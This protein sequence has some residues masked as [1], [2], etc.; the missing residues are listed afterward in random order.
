MKK[1]LFTVLML[2]TTISMLLAEGI[3]REKIMPKKLVYSELPE[4]YPKELDELFQFYYD[5]AQAILHEYEKIKKDNK[6]NFVKELW[7]FLYDRIENMVEEKKFRILYLD[8]LARNTIPLY[9]A[10]FIAL[11]FNIEFIDSIPESE[12]YAISYMPEE[13]IKLWKNYLRIPWIGKIRGAV[14][15]DLIEKYPDKKIDFI[16]WNN[17]IWAKGIVQESEYFERKTSR[18]GANNTKN[19]IKFK[20]TDTIASKFTENEIIIQVGSWGDVMKKNDYY[21]IPIICS[22]HDYH[23][24]DTI[25]FLNEEYGN[26]PVT[27]R[28]SIG[29]SYKLENDMIQKKS[30]PITVDPPSWGDFP[31]TQYET[32]ISYTTFKERIEDGIWY[33]KQKAGMED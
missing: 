4:D 27:Y 28:A 33:I 24:E 20:I 26:N 11:H 16:Y 6:E 17:R 18:I 1:V 5:E 25:I 12:L 14:W 2:T 29:G 3:D 10:E 7:D 8:W 23:F 32:E 15:N 30:R 19:Y 22:Y 13:V 21:V 31:F 9:Y